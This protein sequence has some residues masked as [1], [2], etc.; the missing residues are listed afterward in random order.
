MLHARLISLALPC[1]LMLPAL[2]AAAGP[3]PL[4]QKALAI[5]AS[6]WGLIPKTMHEHEKVFTEEGKLKRVTI[7]DYELFRNKDGKVRAKL[8]KCMRDGK[9]ATRTKQQE[10]DEAIKRRPQDRELFKK[11]NDLFQPENQDL[12]RIKRIDIP[13]KIHGR[14]TVAFDYS[15]RND[16]ATM[17]GVV[18]L[19]AENGTPYHIV[20]RPDRF[21]EHES[22]K[23]H[24]ATLE[25]LFNDPS[26]EGGRWHVET[27]KVRSKIEIEIFL[28]FSFKGSVST[29]VSFSDFHR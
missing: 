8:L 3:D 18:W 12:V 16:E 22:F 21:P 27:M 28:F 6:S 11:R 26:K 19:D 9:D 4:W 24:E 20:T 1:A 29:E 17:N 23:I 14:D 15:M 13:R 7:S 2:P 10:I 5:G 25:F